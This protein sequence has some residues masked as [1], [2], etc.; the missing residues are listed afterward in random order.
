M[1]TQVNLYQPSCYPKREKATFPQ[2]IGFFIIC[3]SVSLASYFIANYQT[4][5]LQEKLADQQTAISEQQVKLEQLVVELQ[6]KRAPDDKLRLHSRLQ[7]EVTAKQRLLASIAGIDVEDLVSFSALMRG[8]SYAN[9]DDLTIN[10]FAMHKGVLNIRGD[11]KHSNSVPLWLSNLQVTK[12]LSGVAF[13][14]LSIE[15]ADGVFSF[16]L[17]NSDTKG[18][19]NE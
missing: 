4:Q 16:K 10:H 17:T 2:F 14:A 18:A 19:A 13:K 15:E 6:K 1:K 12:E 8:L 11:A 5:S 7:N 3:I 9:M